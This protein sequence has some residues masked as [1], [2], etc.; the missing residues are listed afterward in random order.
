[1]VKVRFSWGFLAVGLAATALSCAPAAQRASGKVPVAATA[2]ERPYETFKITYEQELPN[3]KGKSFT[4]A[5]VDFPPNG[6]AVPHRHG[7][8]F[9]Y[10][11]VLEGTFRS[12]LE[13]QPVE[14][15]KEG[16][17]W[18]EPPGAYHVLTENTSETEPGKLL[19]VFVSNTGD[20]LKVPQP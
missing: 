19:V 3:I 15:Y 1:M 10:A 12:Q 8:A 13:G 2:S 9:V 4:S 5:T 16:E 20:E 11:Y 14:T 7:D 17:Y 6:H 18:V